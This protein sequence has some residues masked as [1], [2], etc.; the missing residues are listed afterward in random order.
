MVEDLVI[1]VKVLVELKAKY[2]V[3]TG[4]VQLIN[5]SQTILLCEEI[6]LIPDE[7]TA[8]RCKLGKAPWK[9]QNGQIIAKVQ[10]TNKQQYYMLRV[11]VQDDQ[12]ALKFINT[13]PSSICIK[14]RQLLGYMDLRS[15]GVYVIECEQLLHLHERNIAFMSTEQ[16][17]EILM[18][19]MDIWMK[20]VTQQEE[21]PDPNNPYPWLADSDI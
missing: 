1:G 5:H 13:T 7:E 19:S 2:M 14:T 6:H 15:I 8:I 18:E 11:N 21:E 9:I 10:V 12:L 3:S 4:E 16:T 20:A 17:Q